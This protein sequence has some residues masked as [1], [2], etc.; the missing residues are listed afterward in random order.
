MRDPWCEAQ[1]ALMP[2]WLRVQC[3]E[4]TRD[5]LFLE[6]SSLGPASMFLHTFFLPEMCQVK[7]AEVGRKNFLGYLLTLHEEC[8]RDLM[9]QMRGSGPC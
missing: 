3:R 6:Y 1:K 2:V 4:Q 8:L 5:C 9:N 7:E